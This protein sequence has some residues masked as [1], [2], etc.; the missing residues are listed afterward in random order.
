MRGIA[1]SL[2]A[3]AC[4]AASSGEKPAETMIVR[5]DEVWRPIDMT[6][7][8]VQPGSALDLSGIHEPG[9]AGK[10][11]RVMIGP[12]GTF[13]F[14]KQPEKPVRFFAFYSMANLVMSWKESLVSVGS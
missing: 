2:L 8:S 12:D 10:Y 11:G 14:E 3:G 7:L 4:L 5:P 9:P 1:V 13:R 6:A